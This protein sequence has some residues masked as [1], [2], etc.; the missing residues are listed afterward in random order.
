MIVL[1]YTTELVRLIGLFPTLVLCSGASLALSQCL[2][3]WLGM[4]GPVKD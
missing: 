2:F 3:V 4:T 1:E